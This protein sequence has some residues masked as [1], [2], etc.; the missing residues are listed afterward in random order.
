[1]KYYSAVKKNKLMKFEGKWIEL[2]K[3]ISLSEITQTQTNKDC[4]FSLT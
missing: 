3:K 4:M 1:M 2:E